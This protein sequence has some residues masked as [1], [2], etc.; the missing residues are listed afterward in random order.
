MILVTGGTGFVGRSLVRQLTE[1]GYPVRVLIRPSADSP[2]LPT[3]VAMEVA[4][5][6]LSDERGLLAAMKGV[7]VVY[8]L[9]GAEWRG[10]QA[11]LLQTDIQGA[12]AVAAAARQSR[13]D[14]VFTV[15]HLGADRASA[16]PVLKSKAIAEE[17]FR[18]SGVDFTILR[19]AILFGQDDRFTSGLAQFFYAMPGI[20]LLPGD[21]STLLQP[22][23]VEDLATCLVWALDHENTRNK[24]YEVG[25]PEYLNFR[26]IVELLQY[27]MGIERR[28]VAARQPHLRA[29]TVWLSNFFPALPVSEFWLDYL[30][31]NR[32][33][34][35]DT[36]PRVFGLLPS[37]F[38]SRLD[39][40]H[41]VNWRR[42]MR[43][44]LL[45]RKAA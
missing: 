15:S 16:Y 24:L 7:D 22:L 2:A 10:A 39:H 9:A 11:D 13:I 3:G 6:S 34:S 32:T 26:Q 25:G 14:R 1:A 42:E 45:R 29:L 40:L 4:V 38:L 43:R 23:W 12:R 30:A 20:F 28:L 19:S 27:T 8:H 35:L 33:G 44:S 17:H 18:R 37:R 41:G 5:S 31:A 36:I 21:G